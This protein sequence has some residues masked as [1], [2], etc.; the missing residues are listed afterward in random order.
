[1]RSGWDSHPQGGFHRSPVFGTGAVGLSASRSNAE[2]ERFELPRRSSRLAP[3][4]TVLLVPSGHSPC[5]EGERIER[6]QGSHPDLRLATGCLTSSASLPYAGRDLHP[7]APF[8][9]RASGARASAFRH[10]RLRVDDGSRTRDLH[11]GKVTRCQLRHIHVEPRPESDRVTLPVPG[12]RSATELRGHE[13]RSESWSRTS[14]QPGQSRLANRRW[15]P[16]GMEP[17]P[18]ADP[19]LPPYRGRVT[20]VCD[21]WA[22][23]QAM[24]VASASRTN[25]RSPCFTPVLGVLGAIRTHTAQGPRED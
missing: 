19:G 4:P 24:A 12:V 3:L 22:P 11:L 25:R 10:Q 6:P 17:S 15:S 20:A 1:M 14:N 21:G 5:A 23:A 8:G 16:P 18:G 7:H 13:L 2:S 9:T